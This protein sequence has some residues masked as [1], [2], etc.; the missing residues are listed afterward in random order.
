MVALDRV[1]A[2]AEVAALARLAEA[3]SKF[4]DEP[5]IAQRRET[6]SHAQRDVR[7]AVRG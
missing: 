3:D 5:V 2:D 1:L 7:R 4:A 6:A